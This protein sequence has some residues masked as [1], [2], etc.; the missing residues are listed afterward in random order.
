MYIFVYYI[1]INLLKKK[2]KNIDVRC[3]IRTHCE[4]CQY[5]AAKTAARLES[6]W[7]FSLG[8]GQ[9]AS[10]AVQKASGPGTLKASIGNFQHSLPSWQVGSLGLS[11]G[12][13]Y[14]G[15]IPI[16]QSP[17]ERWNIHIDTKHVE[18]ELSTMMHKWIIIVFLFMN[19]IYRTVY[20]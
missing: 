17:Q 1:H 4:M 6:S 5:I 7:K 15:Y 14:I 9:G 16:S 20:L 18:N 12:R 8:F 3:D 11:D 2:K 19:H 10:S 13:C